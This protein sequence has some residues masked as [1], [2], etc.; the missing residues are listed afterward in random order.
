MHSGCIHHINCKID[1]HLSFV[2]VNYFICMYN[3]LVGCIFHIFHYL[4][5]TFNIKLHSLL[6]TLKKQYLTTVYILRIFK[7]LLS[8]FMFFLLK[9][10]LIMLFFLFHFSLLYHYIIISLLYLFKCVTAA[11]K[12]VKYVYSFIKLLFSF[13]SYCIFCLFKNPKHGKRTE[14]QKVKRHFAP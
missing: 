14:N 8:L 6:K 9:Q 3:S 12:K 5:R 11:C 2:L 13:C 1:V 4:L 7:Y 10:T